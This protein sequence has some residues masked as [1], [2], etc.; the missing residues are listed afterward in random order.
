MKS[1]EYAETGI[2]LHTRAR[3][4]ALEP[5]RQKPA[6]PNSLVC[7][8]ERTT[9][10]LQEQSLNKCNDD[11]NESRPATAGTQVPTQQQS[12]EKRG[13]EL[14]SHTLVVKKTVDGR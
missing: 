8:F 10:V 3:A 12:Y 14:W 11:M 13:D 1:Y 7:C 4:A 5:Q 6:K 9:A 2:E